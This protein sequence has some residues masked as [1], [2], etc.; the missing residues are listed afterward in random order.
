MRLIVVLS[1]WTALRTHPDKNPNDQADAT[2]EFQRVAAAYD[3]LVQYLDNNHDD[4][5]DYSN[6][7]RYSNDEPRMNFYMCSSASFLYISSGR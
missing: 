1:L 7:K 3:T 6:D 5:D 2:R 4:Y